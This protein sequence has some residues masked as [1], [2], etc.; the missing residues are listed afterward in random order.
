MPQDPIV[1]VWRIGGVEAVDPFLMPL[2]MALDIIL[3]RARERM[4]QLDGIERQQTSAALGALALAAAS[5]NGT[6]R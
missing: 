3:T 5:T 6:G 4:E 2:D 1:Q